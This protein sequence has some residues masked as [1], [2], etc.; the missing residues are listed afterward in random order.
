MVSVGQTGSLGREWAIQNSRRNNIERLYGTQI[1]LYSNLIL[2]GVNDDKVIDKIELDIEG[3]T[4]TDS[5]DLLNWDNS[6]WSAGSA[7]DRVFQNDKQNLFTHTD[8]R[9]GT[10]E[11]MDEQSFTEALGMDWSG[12]KP[13]DVF[14]IN[15]NTI[16]FYD[17]VF[18]GTDDGNQENVIFNLNELT[19][20]RWGIN[21][22]TIREV[23]I[24]KMT[25]EKV[26]GDSESELAHDTLRIIQ[27]SIPQWMNANIQRQ[28]SSYEVGTEEYNNKFIELAI[29]MM[30]QEG[31]TKGNEIDSPAEEQLAKAEQ[32]KNDDN[33]V[34]ETEKAEVTVPEEKVE[35]KPAATETEKAEDAKQPV[36]TD[37][38]P[39]DD[40]PE[41]P[42]I[43]VEKPQQGGV[44]SVTTMAVG[45][46]GG[47][48]IPDKTNPTG[49]FTSLEPDN[50][51]IGVTTMA[52]GEEGGLEFGT[53]TATQLRKF[54]L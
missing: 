3:L 5:G 8:L 26:V 10:Y 37:E 47:S 17:F 23:D 13:Y 53:Y 4:E 35:E 48:T 24:D 27:E 33:S 51:D 28:L 29:E 12:G 20:A 6:L 30:D 2:T 52:V 18:A 15:N 46:E 9:K 21:R 38:V 44:G 7:D 14:E 1:D 34:A 43:E 22:Y 45:E 36:V 50:L 40:E 25:S 32:K 39:E 19:E 31:Y 49:G 16:N 54:T 42:F 41:R 11:V